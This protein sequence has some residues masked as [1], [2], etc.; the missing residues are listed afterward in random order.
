M[1]ERN[2]LPTAES[3]TATQ[4]SLVD[5]VFAE[6][7]EEIILEDANLHVVNRFNAYYCHEEI[8]GPTAA[9][10]VLAEAVIAASEHTKKGRK[11]C[12]KK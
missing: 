2:K 11:K 3:D 8:D 9:L 4:E 1:R 6:P 12:K 10:L 7:E 5:D